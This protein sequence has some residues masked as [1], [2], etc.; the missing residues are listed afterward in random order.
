MPIYN[1]SDQVVKNI[2]EIIGN[3]D[4]KGRQSMA[5]V[6][7]LQSLQ[8]PVPPKKEPQDQPDGNPTA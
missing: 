1:L 7:I 2:V 6:E 4:I 5:I 8:R 3:A